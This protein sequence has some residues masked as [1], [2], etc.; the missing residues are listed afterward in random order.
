MWYDCSKLIYFLLNFILIFK[1]SLGSQNTEVY[2]ETDKEFLIIQNL[3]VYL[4]LNTYQTNSMHDL[5]VS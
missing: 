1:D 3:S 5:M 2:F 4:I